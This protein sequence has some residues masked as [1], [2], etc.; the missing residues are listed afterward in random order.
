MSEQRDED[1]DTEDF[2]ST[3][4][5]L[6]VSVPDLGDDNFDRTVVFMVEHD[7][8]GALGLVLNRPSDT[9]VADHLP[10]LADGTLSPQVFFIGG[11]VS[12]GGLMALGRRSL[13]ATLNHAVTIAGP[14]VMIDPQALVN[15]EVEG[16][17]ALR[18]FTGY[19]GWGAGQL[20]SE[21]ASG[22][23]YVVE[24]MADDVLC[25]DPDAL[26]RAVMRRQ[27]GKLAS[28]ALYPDD[29]RSN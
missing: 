25:A 16:V 15:G 26:W 12:V 6:L 1:A 21:V 9:E 4:G 8:N 20:D 29:L 19:S 3:A 23:W 28:Q 18:L 17:E 11:P 27:G 5:Q 22:V 13:D 10:Q 14:V 2:V 24:A 7:G